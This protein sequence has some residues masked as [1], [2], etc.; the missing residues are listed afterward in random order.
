MHD[1]KDNDRRDSAEDDP[2]A[3]ASATHVRSRILKGEHGEDGPDNQ[4]IVVRQH[5]ETRERRGGQPENNLTNDVLNPRPSPPGHDDR[6]S[7][8]MDAP[9]GQPPAAEHVEGRRGDGLKKPV[10]RRHKPGWLH[11]S[12]PSS[13]P[14]IEDDS[15]RNRWPASADSDVERGRLA[16]LRADGRPDLA[17]QQRRG[18]Q[19]G[20]RCADRPQQSHLIRDRDRHEARGERPHQTREQKPDQYRRASDLDRRT[21]RPTRPVPQGSQR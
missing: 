1:A 12:Q 3:S 2:D 21:D 19:D 15:G 4:R 6:R 11:F 9:S 14:G 7:E 13:R 10:V 16:D 17:D 8:R 5:G 18:D 20:R